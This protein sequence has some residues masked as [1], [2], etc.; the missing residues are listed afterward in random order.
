M[1]QT[2]STTAE[3]SAWQRACRS[4]AEGH[5]G[6]AH[7][8][9]HR[10]LSLNGDCG[11]GW[12]LLG[13]VYHAWRQWGQ[14]RAALEEASVRVPLS[15]VAE[16]ALADCYLAEGPTEWARSL[17]HQV[18]RRDSAT[19]PALLGTAAGLDVLDEPDLAVI[20]CRRA[21]EF[22]PEAAQPY[23]DL[24]YYLGRCGAP[25]SRIEA[26]ARHAIQL[27]PDNITYRI[28]LAGFLH[29]Q[30][31]SADGALLI[32]GLTHE[33]VQGMQC[34]C[35]LARLIGVFEAVSD[36]ERACWCRQRQEVLLLSREGH[37]C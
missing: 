3:V 9:L 20:A 26:S 34:Q 12:E 8:A 21:I 17:Y 18:L 29:T 28:G 23:F 27:A 35:C 11:R 33:H 32:G 25:V 10:H 24:S 36:D 16:C 13:L 7:R 37:S 6:V 22:D 14:A 15:S 31:R 1:S 19:L 4:Y 30:G 5:L 2:E